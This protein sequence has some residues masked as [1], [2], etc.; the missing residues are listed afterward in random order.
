[1]KVTSHSA[2]SAHGGIFSCAQLPAIT[3]ANLKVDNDQQQQTKLHRYRIGAS[4]PG[5]CDYYQRNPEAAVE[6]LWEQPRN[7]E[8]RY[9]HLPAC[10]D[11]VEGED[12][13]MAVNGF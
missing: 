12:A 13:L 2:R 5:E 6:P 4:R 11:R 9:F 7:G 10:R 1:M 8:R 3:L